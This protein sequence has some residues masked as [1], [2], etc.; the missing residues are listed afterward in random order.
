MR[1]QQP[2]TYLAH[3]AA[4]PRQSGYMVCGSTGAGVRISHC[5]SQSDLAQQG[6]IR[7][8]ITNE[9]TLRGC[10]TE[11]HGQGAEVVHLIA[12]AL[13]HVGN[14]EFAAATRHRRRAAPGYD[15]DIDAGMRQ[16]LQSVAVLDVEALQ[17]LAARAVIQ[18][19]IGEHA[20]HIQD[21]QANRGR[22]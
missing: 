22:G 16:R 14:G 11:P 5:E 7:D 20:I 15:G 13:D 1:G 12:T 6:N 10:H 2:V 17:L 21:Q 4:A 19:A 9:C 8:V 3:G 18:A